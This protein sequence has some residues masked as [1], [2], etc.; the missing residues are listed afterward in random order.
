MLSKQDAERRAKY[1]GAS[2]VP[3]LFGWN[4][5]KKPWHVYWS[6]M[7][8]ETWPDEYTATLKPEGAESKAIMIGNALEPAVLRLMVGYLGHEADHEYIKDEQ[9]VHKDGIILASLDAQLSCFTYRNKK[10][11]EPCV[12]EAKTTGFAGDPLERWGRAMSQDIPI[13]VMAQVQTQLLATGWKFA[14]I[15]LLSGHDASGLKMY[16]ITAEP[17]LQERIAE[18]TQRFWQQYIMRKHPPQQDQPYV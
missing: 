16:R 7:P 15:G 13:R 3:C 2:D 4:A 8:Q 17:K 6:K 1:V 14:F 9:H 11:N 12:L 18:T 10:I 5:W